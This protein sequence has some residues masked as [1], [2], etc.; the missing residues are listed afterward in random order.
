MSETQTT[1]AA[2]EATPPAIP[3]NLTGKIREYETNIVLRPDLTEDQV[4]KFREK[5]R[6]LVARDG[7]KVIKFKTWQKK[8]L[9]FYIKNFKTG[10][11][12]YVHYVGPTQLAAELE[13]NLRISDENLRYLTVKLADSASLEKAVEADEKF[14]GDAEERPPREDRPARAG[15]EGGFEGEKQEE[16]TDEGGE[17]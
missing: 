15:D 9:A 13:R 8:K 4:E 12:V 6:A 11:Y 1:A 17:E 3:A 10:V 14:A 7:G 5:I 2:P 16:G